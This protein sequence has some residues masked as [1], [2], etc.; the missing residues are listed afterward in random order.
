[1]QID[2]ISKIHGQV[3]EADAGYGKIKII[4]LY[5]PAVALYNPELKE[6]M[7]KDFQKLKEA[8]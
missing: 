2:W 6:V 8:I 5:H 4:P 1:M 3:F 7:M